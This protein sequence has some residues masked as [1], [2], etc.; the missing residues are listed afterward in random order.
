[1]RFRPHVTPP[2]LIVGLV[3][4]ALALPP[5]ASNAWAEEFTAAQRAEIV[6]IIRDALKR[7]PS[8][9]REAVI[10]LQT[11]DGEREKSAGRAAVSAARDALVTPDDPIAGNARG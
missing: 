6:T 7:D 4:S 3:L 1:M 9:L 2:L 11:E 5:A 10:A 8:I